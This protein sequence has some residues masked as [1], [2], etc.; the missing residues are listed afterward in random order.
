M[1]C[2]F[3]V[4]VV[5]VVVAAAA[6]VV[7]VVVAAAPVVGHYVGHHDASLGKYWH[8]DWLEVLEILLRGHDIIA[9]FQLRHGCIRQ[10][11][12]SHRHHAVHFQRRK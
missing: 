7:V 9:S 4:V 10:A 11:Y 6:A 12:I 1:E 3:A 8:W 5:V 2:T